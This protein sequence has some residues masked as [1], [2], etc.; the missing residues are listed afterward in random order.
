VFRLCLV[1]LAGESGQTMERRN[2]GATVIKTE[3]PYLSCAAQTDATILVGLVEDQSQ[4]R[5]TQSP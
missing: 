1:H 4:C 5:S 2:K 3:H